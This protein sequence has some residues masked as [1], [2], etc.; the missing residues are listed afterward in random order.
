MLQTTTIDRAAKCF[1]GTTSKCPAKE[2]YRNVIDL[3]GL[4]RF[5][6]ITASDTASLRNA[7]SARL[8]SFARP[9]SRDP[10]E[11]QRLRPK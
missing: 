4:F 5:A 11:T 9:V 3:G 6:A 10:T 8:P 7:M 2:V 1:G